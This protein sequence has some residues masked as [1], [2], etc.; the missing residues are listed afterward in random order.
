MGRC[1]TLKSSKQASY[2]V[3]TFKMVPGPHHPCEMKMTMSRRKRRKNKS[4]I[5]EALLAILKASCLEEKKGISIS[6]T[7]ASWVVD[8]EKIITL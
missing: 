1:I 8:L 6:W 3:E 5:Y 7:V 2:I 4:N